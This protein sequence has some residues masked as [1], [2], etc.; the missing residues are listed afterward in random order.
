MELG[1][2]IWKLLLVPLD[3]FAFTMLTSW[4]TGRFDWERKQVLLGMG[5]LLLQAGAL[6]TRSDEFSLC[7]TFGY[8]F[9]SICLKTHRGR[10]RAFGNTLVLIFLFVCPLNTVFFVLEVCG[11]AAYT[12]EGDFLLWGA[13]ALLDILI[14]A[15]VWRMRHYRSDVLL[16]FSKGEV[17]LI[18]LIFFLT[19]LLG[20]SLDPATGV[21]SEE[22]LEAP[23][24]RFFLGVIAVT[25]VLVNGL[26]LL[27]M[28]KNKTSDYYRYL[29]LEHR[30]YIE[31]ELR[32]FEVYKSA[33]TDL[34]AFRHD[35]KHHIS[36]LQQLCD[37][38]DLDKI[39][40]YVRELD[41]NWEH[42]A[43]SLHH[44][45]DDTVDSIFNAKAWLMRK[46]NIRF[47]LSG[48]FAGKLSISPF[49]LCAIFSNAL[50]NA[51]QAVRRVD[52]DRFVAVT[53]C[54]SDY[55]YMVSIENPLGTAEEHRTGKEAR[56][57]GFGLSSIREK[58]ER[59]GGDIRIQKGGGRFL[60]ELYL[61][62]APFTPKN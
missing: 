33:Q 10:L 24:A 13:G 45:G 60:L 32:Y 7:V 42:A 4:V 61:P 17:A 27:M 6:F 23:S 15:F 44:T 41:G 53:I 9:L 31:N 28:W 47:V 26:F 11:V 19:I 50:D 37:G 16:R 34:R 36:Y 56:D 18:V 57:H 25:T 62:V 3:L 30:Q 12:G 21:L 43:Q 2:F 49:D 29:N 39:R 22:A 14:A 54:R 48:A 46:E 20:V 40:A 35:M 52:G 58:A 55:Y 38:G 59:N 5:A 51:V 1:L 8:V